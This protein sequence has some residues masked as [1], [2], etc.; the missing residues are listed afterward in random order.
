MEVEVLQSGVQRKACHHNGESDLARS[1]RAVQLM[2]RYGQWSHRR[3]ILNGLEFK[4]NGKNDLK[5]VDYRVDEER[6]ERFVVVK[7]RKMY[8]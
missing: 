3:F 8:R 1:K 2:S 5:S 7:K 6:K 4:G